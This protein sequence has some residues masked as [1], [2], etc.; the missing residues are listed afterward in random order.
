VTV[1]CSALDLDRRAHYSAGFNAEHYRERRTRT[2]ADYLVRDF[3]CVHAQLAGDH[4][5][6]PPPD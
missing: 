5:F 4:L 6:P 3:C 2:D 1:L